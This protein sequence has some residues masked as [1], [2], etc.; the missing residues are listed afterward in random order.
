[1]KKH[2]CLIISLLCA[3]QAC[4][5]DTDYIDP[6]SS[7]AGSEK[8]I[9]INTK[10]E[11]KLFI[12]NATFPDGSVPYEGAITTR[13]ATARTE[14]CVTNGCNAIRTITSNTRVTFSLPVAQEL[15]LEPAKEYICDI[16][17]GEVWVRES[18]EFTIAYDYSPNCGYM[19]NAAYTDKG[20]SMV[21]KSNTL[22]FLSNELY[23]K[24]DL[25]NNPIN[26]H[27]PKEAENFVW[28]FKRIYN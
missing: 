9:A 1:M 21:R 19:P 20:Y 17:Q 8:C 16:R 24:W 11:L 5:N 4:T 3:F 23:I 12:A 15:G 26:R 27:Y 13:A 14:Y 10:E 18:P 7:N 6:Q 2:L 28:N 22:M 25:S